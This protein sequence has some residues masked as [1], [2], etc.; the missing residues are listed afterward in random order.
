MTHIYSRIRRT[1]DYPYNAFESGIKACGNSV[2][3]DFPD[4]GKPENIFLSWNYYGANQTAG[5]QFKDNGGRVFVA[6]NA[7]VMR[8]K[9]YALAQ[10]GHNGRGQANE[11]PTPDRWD[12]FQIPINPWRD[13]GKYILVCGQRGGSYSDMS[14]PVDW[15]DVVYDKLRLYTDRPI[16]YRPHPEIQRYPVN[17]EITVV[18]HKQP[19]CFQLKDVHAVVVYTSNAATNALLHGVP[20]FYEGPS[21][22]CKDICN[23]NLKNIESPMTFDREPVFWRLAWHQWSLDEIRTG[24]AWKWAT[25]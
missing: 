13:S 15:P 2:S 5:D 14:M 12:S 23:D 19:F 3:Y 9:Y 18:S 4:P 21:V 20:V 6:E 25:Q 16:L 17:K 24:V 11:V 22:M 1:D 7:Y 10:N 8:G